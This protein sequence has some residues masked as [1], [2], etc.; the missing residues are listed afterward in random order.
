MCKSQRG[1][2]EIAE[3][4]E[5]LWRVRLFEGPV[6]ENSS[7]ELVRRF[8]S[9]KAGGLFAYLALRLGRFCS[10]EDIGYALWPEEYDLQVVANRLR[11][12]LAS[13]RRQLEPPGTPFGA[14]IDVSNPGKIS[15]REETVWCDVAAFDKAHKTGNLQEAARLFKGKLLPGYYDD[16]VLPEQERFERLSRELSQIVVSEESKPEFHSSP[17]RLGYLSRFHPPLPLYLTRWFGREETQQELREALYE[18]RLVSIVGPGGIGKTRLSIETAKEM[19]LPAVFVSLAEVVDPINIPDA[20]LSALKISVSSNSDPIEQLISLLLQREPCLII[21]DNAEHLVEATAQ[22][23]LRLLAEAPS[24]TILV[25][26][27]QSLNIAGERLFPLGAIET[28]DLDTPFKSLNDSPSVALFLDRAR[29]AR[30]DF[31]L[32]PKNAPAIVRICQ[33]LEGMPLG[34]ELAAARVVIQ[35][36]IQIEESL[37]Q[38]LM[39]LESHLHGFSIR[40][41]SLRASIQGSFDLLT[42][43]QKTFFLSLSIFQGGWTVEAARSVSNC[44]ETQ[45]LLAELSHRSL[46]VIVEDE[47]IGIMRGSF[48]ETIRQFALEKLSKTEFQALASR[49]ANY[50]LTLASVVDNDDYLTF[51]PIEIELENLLLALETGSQA[52]DKLF[53]QG[54]CGSLTYSYVRGARRIAL[55]WSKRTLELI[56]AIAEIEMR[57]RLGFA[58]YNLISYSGNLALSR[59]IANEMRLDSAANHYESGVAMADL[60]ESFVLTCE[61]D[62]SGALLLSRSAI[63]RAKL[64][65]NLMLVRRG[66]SL[67]GWICCS[68]IKIDSALDAVIK[69]QLLAEGEAT[70]SEALAMVPEKSCSMTYNQLNLYSILSL[71]DRAEDAYAILK[72][73][74][75]SALTSGATSMM[76]FSLF[77]E[78][79]IAAQKENLEY[80]AFFY[81]SYEALRE[82]TGYI[83]TNPNFD[84]VQTILSLSRQLGKQRYEALFLAG[85]QCSLVQVIALSLDAPPNFSPDG[86]LLSSLHH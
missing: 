2:F 15:L 17:Q 55:A 79:L 22:F 5:K 80:A 11:V 4:I 23:A 47:A 69:N 8:R 85:S 12:A 56:P 64:D 42:M 45:E 40:H 21:L 18:N 19:K 49:H 58:C 30:P 14:V 31:I 75:K 84:V 76:I 66:L 81:G 60:I 37:K 57:V 7:G 46:L 54:L 9:Q 74:Q 44:E 43:E 52:P 68:Y 70:T 65:K 20:T 24:L 72:Q 13:L 73:T 48:L 63:I 59:S 82:R 62:F 51:A 78:C 32:T 50:F 26:S 16:W 33:A 28:Y 38:G 6:L 39:A 61:S 10:R 34:I 53:W 25:T 29:N 77:Q 67:L 1:D 71:E 35:T 83:S 86:T 36:P 3:E 27:R 41:R